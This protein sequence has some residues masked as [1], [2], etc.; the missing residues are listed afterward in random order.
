MRVLNEDKVILSPLMSER[1]K[2]LHDDKMKDTD[3]KIQLGLTHDSDD[4]GFVWFPEFKFKAPIE[5]DARPLY[6]PKNL[7]KLF[8]RFMNEMPKYVNKASALGGA[9]V[10]PMIDRKFFDVKLDFDPQFAID[11]ETR[12]CWRKYR[13]SPGYL[14]MNHCGPD[15]KIGLKLGWQGL[16]EKVRYYRDF[17]NPANTDFYDGEEEVVLAMQ[18]FVKQTADKAREMAEAETDPVAKQN[19][20]EIADMNDYLVTGVPRT[21]REA[22]QFIAHF[23]TADRT[24]FVGGALDQLDEV[25]RPYYEK[26]VDAGIVTDEEAVWYIASLF[27]NDTH[28]SQIAGLIPDGSRDLTSRMSFIILD[29]VHYLH[30]PI[31]I[32]LRVHDKVNETLLRRS[33]EYCAEDGSGVDYSLSTGVEEGYKKN[34]YSQ[35]L[36][37]QRAKVGC[38]WVALPGIEYPLQDVTRANMGF[39]FYYA[40]QDIRDDNPT[41]EKLWDRFC[42]H[43]KTI[44]DSIKHG[45]DKHYEEVGNYTPEIVLNLFM[46]GPIERGLNA[47]QGC[48]VINFNIDGIAL[49]TVAD[50]FAAIEQR[51]VNEER[52]SW[53]K[54][55]EVLDANYEGYEDIRLMFANIKRFGN[56]ES[57]AEKWACKIR[58]YYV[59][60]CKNEGTPK[61]HLPIIPGMFSHGDILHRG[62]ELPATPNGR[63]YGEAIS[64]SNEPDPGFARG[65]DSFSPTLKANAVAIARPGY[66]NSAPLH[67][68]IDLDMLEKAGGV[69]ALVALIH[70]HDHMGGMLINLNILSEKILLEAHADPSTHPDL[71]VRVTGYS[72]FFNTLTKD[73]RQQ[74]VDR[75]LSRKK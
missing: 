68:D 19:L 3:V 36:A 30:I 39:A 63:K 40:L 73:Y 66:G 70:A 27:F 4:W 16:L 74:V 31:N 12:E 60:C 2:T 7:G 71:V 17:N 14:G 67:L 56:P 8:R 5:T 69:D 54:M 52:I 58:D 38:N 47:S 10:G 21:L 62:R 37:R 35:H 13:T 59:W 29:A 53:E 42:Y 28:Y 49:A 55:Y 41:L 43:V 48:D 9:W 65:L 33:L 25:L 57:I 26:D 22:C 32:A 75:F 44:V 23:Q 61:H 24:Y 18:E 64:H 20:I 6:G 34:G 50:S 11:E 45:Y 15:I 51:V 46:H 72:A 1:I